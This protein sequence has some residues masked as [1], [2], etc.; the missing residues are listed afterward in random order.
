ME[1]RFAAFVFLFGAMSPMYGQSTGVL[2]GSIEFG[3][4]NGAS[5][6]IRRAGAS[7]PA[8]LCSVDRML[9]TRSD[10]QGKFTFVN[11]PPGEYELIFGSKFVKRVQIKG[12]EVEPVTIDWDAKQPWEDSACIRDVFQPCVPTRFVI[13]YGEPESRTSGL[14]SGQVHDALSR[15]SKGLA[16]ALVSLFRSGES[17]LR[18]SVVSDKS[19]RF[20]LNPESGV[21]D[22]TMSRDGF[23]GVRISKFLVPRENDTKV[24]IFTMRTGRIVVCE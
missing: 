3:G 13:E 21:Y 2:T 1:C 16:K 9:E 24:G 7:F 20:Q 14:L 11:V 18:Y 4:L 10:G 8:R 19:G 17:S 22:L 6:Q 5:G 15:G 23:Q 12:G